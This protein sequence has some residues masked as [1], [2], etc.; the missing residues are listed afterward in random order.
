MVGLLSCVTPRMSDKQA[1]ASHL[2]DTHLL[3][4]IPECL[5]VAAEHRVQGMDGPWPAH[6]LSP[7]K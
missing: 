1:A 4:D 2:L 7:C 6:L 5:N 3:H